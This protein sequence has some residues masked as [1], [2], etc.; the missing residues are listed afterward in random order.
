[1][2]LLKSG[3]DQTK[4][5]PTAKYFYRTRRRTVH[6]INKEKNKEDYKAAEAAKKK[7]K[8]GGLKELVGNVGI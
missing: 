8:Q 7:L 4:K 5:C 6:L 2:T 3:K 1:M